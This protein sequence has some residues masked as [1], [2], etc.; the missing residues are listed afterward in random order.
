MAQARSSL[1]Y[2]FL[3]SPGKK[4]A[5]LSSFHPI[6]GCYFVSHTY[7]LQLR[8]VERHL[9]RF[10]RRVRPRAAAP[11]TATHFLFYSPEDTGC[12]A[13]CIRGGDPTASG[14]AGGG[15]AG[16]HWAAERWCVDRDGWGG[17]L[18]AGGTCARAAEARATEQGP[19]VTVLGSISCLLSCVLL[20][21]AF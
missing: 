12:A 13:C 15:R 10:V 9:A 7:L 17:C 19:F 21:D 11:L 6:F 16:T 1:S 5:L 8:S 4:S 20:N 14:A 3:F 2:Y 18:G